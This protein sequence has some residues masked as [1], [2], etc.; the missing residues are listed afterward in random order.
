MQL[1]GYK[2]RLNKNDQMWGAAIAEWICLPLPSSCPGFRVPS[3]PSALLS[4]IV[5]CYIFHVKR[6]KKQKEGGCGPFK[7]IKLY[8]WSVNNTT[9][10]SKLL[11]SV[12]NH[13]YIANYDLRVKK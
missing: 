6:T 3:T 1:G 4:F 10:T 9:G 2:I 7:K 12:G 11:L 5:L 8:Q 13:V